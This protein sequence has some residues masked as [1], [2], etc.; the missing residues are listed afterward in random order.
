MPAFLYNYVRFQMSLSLEVET[1]YG[2]SW[3]GTRGGQVSS[4][5]TPPRKPTSREARSLRYM[6]SSSTRHPHVRGSR[7]GNNNSTIYISVN[8]TMGIFFFNHFFIHTK[9]TNN[10]GKINMY[11]YM[12]V[13]A[14]LWADFNLQ[15]LACHR[16][17]KHTE[18]GTEEQ[19]I[20]QLSLSQARAAEVYATAQTPVPSL[21]LR[22]CACHCIIVCAKLQNHK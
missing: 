20:R 1:L 22:K 11:T 13:Y 4:A 8:M 19:C 18:N 7:P 10:D 3:Q 17:S 15:N 9:P 2:P 5:I 21:M 12:Y 14:I 16:T 6:F